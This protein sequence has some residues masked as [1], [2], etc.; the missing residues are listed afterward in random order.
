VG[1]PPPRIYVEA[2]ECHECG[3]SGINDSNS[4]DAACG[5]PCGWTGPSPKEDVCPGCGRDNVMRAACPKC[6]GLYGLIA[7]GH[8]D[9][10]P[11]ASAEDVDQQPANC[12]ETR[13]GACGTGVDVDK[14]LD[15]EFAE[16]LSENFGDL[17]IRPNAH[18]KG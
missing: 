15:G 8:I 13:A 1:Q 3:H 4:T 9:A 17:C 12:P 7:D 6:G 14:P 5:Y 11:Q 18:A 2:R 10:V 16:V